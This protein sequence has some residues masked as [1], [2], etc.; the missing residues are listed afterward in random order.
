MR[1]ADLRIEDL[2]K[3]FYLGNAL[4]LLMKATLKT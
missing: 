4:R 2:D 1:E 3:G